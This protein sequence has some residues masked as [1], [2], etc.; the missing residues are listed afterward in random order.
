MSRNFTSI[1][2]VLTNKHLD[3]ALHTQNNPCEG[4]LRPPRHRCS[5]LHLS[6]HIPP[7]TFS[8]Q[9]CAQG[10]HQTRPTRKIRTQ[11]S[12]PHDASLSP[13]SPGAPAAQPSTPAP[14]PPS[15]PPDPAVPGPPAS[16]DVPAACAAPRTAPPL[17][18]P[19][20]LS[21]P[22]PLSP[23]TLFASPPLSLPPL[24][25]PQPLPPRPLRAPPPT[26]LS[27]LS[28]PARSPAPP[29]P[30]P[31]LLSG[32]PASRAGVSR[33]QHSL[34]TAALWPTCSGALHRRSSPAASDW[35]QL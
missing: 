14:L 5:H 31:A 23:G 19:R 2:A 24:R 7:P 34:R 26:P 3:S 4:D 13:A 27:P 35:L 16:E 33:C 21:A 12:S 29:D 18:S 9:P 17:L 22:P 28:P 32:R 25:A 8:T 10:L 6:A 30:E 15:G 11:W 20:P 1:D